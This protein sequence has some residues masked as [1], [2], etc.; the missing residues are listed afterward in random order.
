MAKGLLQPNSPGVE[1][2]VGCVW[3]GAHDFFN[4]ADTSALFVSMTSPGMTKI[5]CLWVTIELADV[6]IIVVDSNSTI[7]TSKDNLKK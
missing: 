5:V 1:L 6:A 7:E 3:G 2:V 4:A